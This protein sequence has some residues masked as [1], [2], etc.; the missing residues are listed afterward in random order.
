M[1][2]ERRPALRIGRLRLRV[3]GRTTDEGW[4]LAAALAARLAALS[5]KTDGRVGGLHVRVP[6]RGSASPS[7]TAEAVAA[8]VAGRLEGGGDA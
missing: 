8:R 3:P 7:E 2:E 5:P 4:A 1:R 6:V